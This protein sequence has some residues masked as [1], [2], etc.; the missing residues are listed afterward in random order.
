MLTD[1]RV[2]FTT[3]FEGWLEG[4]GSSERTIRA[5]LQDVRS[6]VSWFENEYQ[7]AF[8]PQMVTSVDL[9][10][11]RSH[12]LEVERV[13]P[14]TWNRRRISMRLFCEWAGLES[15]L[16]G[17][18]AVEQV[19][20]PPRWLIPADWK[21]FMRQ[22]EVDVN[23][24][25]SDSWKSQA[26]R[27]QAMVALMVYA[28]L[29]EGEVVGL[30][31]GDVELRERSGRVVIRRGKGDKRREVP[32]CNE[33]RIALGAW[34]DV[35]GGD[36]GALFCGK[37]TGRVTTRTVQRRVAEIG[38]RAG[39]DVTPHDLRH[40]FAKRLLDGGTSINVVSRLLGHS[41]LDTTARYVQPGWADYERAVSK[42]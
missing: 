24:A 38:K 15:A 36:P 4:R 23:G 14:A 40:T 3:D 22:L 37:G 8:D 16:Q 18:E 27:D 19:E 11:W 34:M 6:F 9:R 26:V 32:L 7:M 1:T 33:V 39:V 41:R 35:R 42:L 30:D 5:Y 13:A 10:A 25:T 2:F 21:R 28:G 29:R 31:V 20:L 12:S 17:V